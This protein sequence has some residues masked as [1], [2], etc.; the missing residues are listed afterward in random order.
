MSNQKLDFI[1]ANIQM[2]ALSLSTQRD[3]ETRRQTL[4]KIREESYEATFK[5]TNEIPILKP[6]TIS[7]QPKFGLEDL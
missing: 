7:R 1:I 6:I 3:A 5:V 4:I 2:L